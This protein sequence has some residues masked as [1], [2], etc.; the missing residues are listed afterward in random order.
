[1]NIDVLN[2]IDYLQEHPNRIDKLMERIVEVLEEVQQEGYELYTVI[3]Q[4]Q[5]E[6][7][8]KIEETEAQYRAS[9]RDTLTPDS[10]E[11][12]GY[13]PKGAAA[14]YRDAQEADFYPAELKKQYNSLENRMQKLSHSKET[15]DNIAQQIVDIRKTTDDITQ[16]S[17]K[18]N[19]IYVTTIRRLID[20]NKKP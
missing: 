12:R 14:S 2:D 18:W 17:K 11:I 7:K 6:C 19:Q 15:L 1:M 3:L 13:N 20:L 4:K 5:Q 8:S 16:M 9:R 10:R